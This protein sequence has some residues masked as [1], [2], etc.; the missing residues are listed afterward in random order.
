MSCASMRFRVQFI[1][2]RFRIFAQA[3]RIAPSILAVHAHRAEFIAEGV[4]VG[5]VI[6][7]VELRVRRAQRKNKNVDHNH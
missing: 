6:V 5:I 3:V 2:R 1:I 4:S 7:R